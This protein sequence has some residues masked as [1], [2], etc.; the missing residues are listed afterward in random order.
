[1]EP[2][3][4]VE[5][6]EPVTERDAI[7]KAYTESQAGRDETA[8][9]AEDEAK[10]E[11]SDNEEVVTPSP[12]EKDAAASAGDE[13]KGDKDT[14]AREAQ[15]MVPYD[16]LH[17]ERER[18]KALQMEVEELKYRFNQIPK[19]E[20]VEVA[21]LEGF[22]NEG[23]V[24]D[25]EVA[26]KAILKENLKIKRELD[27]V[28]SKSTVFESNYQN[29]VKQEAEAKLAKRVENTTKELAEEGFPGF[30]EFIPLMSAELNKLITEDRDNVRFD[31]EAGWKQIYKERIFPKLATSIG[32]HIKKD[33][34]E[35]KKTLKEKANLATK[36]G[37]Q[38]SK[39]VKEEEWT[40]GDYM[41]MRQRYN[42][43]E[44]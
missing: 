13:G 8:A 41:K 28:K 40:K 14:K 11:T 18:R 23:N 15:K 26:M 16:A 24:T 36:P 22:D 19:Q 38:P 25:Y 34:F 3:E 29:T 6:A 5:T 44:L 9:S 43:E 17:E 42:T 7:Y 30:S 39:Q 33:S 32:E 2:V 4:K 37:A 1:M 21:T 20:K 31:N 12:D 27:T 10:E 35:L